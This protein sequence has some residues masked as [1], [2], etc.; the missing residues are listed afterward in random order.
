[1]AELALR[2]VS[3]VGRELGR[4]RLTDLPSRLTVLELLERRI[5]AEV[6]EYN[7]DPGPVYVGFV[8]PEGAVRY[9]D[10]HR[11]ARPRRL[12]AERFV[13]ATRAAITA[14]LVGFVVDGEL[15]RD[16]STVV[17]PDELDEV[18]IRLERPVIARD[19]DPSA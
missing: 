13:A 1:M 19:P 12:D 14:G 9:S 6:R 11:L 5:R 16:P 2:D 8:Q 18:V 15:T 17:A 4:A 3:R 7:R 10:G